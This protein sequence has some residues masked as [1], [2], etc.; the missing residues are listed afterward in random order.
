MQVRG[1]CVPITDSVECTPLLDV[2]V[3][4]G[5]GGALKHRDCFGFGR[6]AF[7]TEIALRKGVDEFKLLGESKHGPCEAASPCGEGRVALLRRGAAEDAAG[8]IEDGLMRGTAAQFGH[9]VAV[10][11]FAVVNAVLGGCC[12]MLKQAG[13]KVYALVLFA[14]ECVAE[15]MGHCADP[16]GADGVNEE[17]VGAVERVNIAATGERGPAG[18]LNGATD[19]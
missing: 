7:G 3:A 19:L 13:E 11:P 12:C 2:K 14:D 5:A 8:G 1:A 9:I 16:E 15:L 10:T 4:G 6:E 18:G 17:R